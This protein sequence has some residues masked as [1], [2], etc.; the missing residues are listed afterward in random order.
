MAL[1][2][3]RLADFEN[4][5]RD[6]LVLAQPIPPEA[7]DPSISKK[8]ETVHVVLDG[9]GKVL[10][11][12]AKARGYSYA[13]GQLLEVVAASEPGATSVLE[14]T[15]HGLLSLPD[16]RAEADLSRGWDVTVLPRSIIEVK[17]ISTQSQSKKIDV[18]LVIQS[19]RICEKNDQ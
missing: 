3:L 13:G 12:G 18:F 1:V 11:D 7:L 15:E 17:Q 19:A 8:L 10:V 6:Y 9:D 4:C 5:Q 16:S 14:I 2:S